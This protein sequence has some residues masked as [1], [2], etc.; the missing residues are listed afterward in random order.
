MIIPSFDRLEGKTENLYSLCV[1][2]A[3]RAR[4]LKD[5]MVRKL[6][7]ARSNHPLT[8]ALEEIAEEKIKSLYT[9]PPVQEFEDMTY[10]EQEAA[11]IAA[12]EEPEQPSVE[13]TVRE[14]LSVEHD[15]DLELEAEE[16]EEGEDAEVVKDLFEAIA[17]GDVEPVVTPEDE[18]EEEESEEKTEEHAEEEEE[19][20]DEDEKVVEGPVADDWSPVEPKDDQEK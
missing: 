18:D 2:A 6:A 5:P 12:D 9:E 16:V 1:L 7:E 13:D 11:Q 14:L 20:E 15:D 4:Q 19:E 3:K 8:I 17:S 10:E